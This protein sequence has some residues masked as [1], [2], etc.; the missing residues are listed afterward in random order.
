[1]TRSLVSIGVALIDAGARP[2]M[3]RWLLDLLG[4]TRR[5]YL[6]RPKVEAGR[7]QTILRF[8]LD[9]RELMILV[10]RPGIAYWQRILPEGVLDQGPLGP[11]ASQC[12]RQ[13]FDWLL[14]DAVSRVS[15]G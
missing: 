13:L 2:D 7:S 12:V 3:A 4:S 10:A 5:V 14:N 11:V 8:A 1:M 6:P 15:P 9:D